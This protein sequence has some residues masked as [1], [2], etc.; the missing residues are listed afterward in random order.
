MTSLLSEDLSV[1]GDALSPP[2]SS[3][4]PR[5]TLPHGELSAVSADKENSIVSTSSRVCS[6]ASQTEPN[7]PLIRA[8]QSVYRQICLLNCRVKG[9]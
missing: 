6:P 9:E 5:H 8:L 1:A 4:A 7:L 2:A 3:V